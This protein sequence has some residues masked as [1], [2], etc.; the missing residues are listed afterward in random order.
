METAMTSKV[1]S[2]RKVLYMTELALL[3]AIVILMAFTPLGYL[4]TPF[5]EITFIVVPVAIGA[6]LLDWKAGAFLGFV[7]GLTS[8]AQCFG[9]SPFGTMIFNLYPAR[10]AFCCIAP[11]IMVGIVPALA[12]K[13]L[14]SVRSLKALSI[15][16]ACV[17]APLTNT[18]LYL[19][20]MCFI[21][22]GPFTE[23]YGYTGKGGIYFLFWVLAMVMVNALMEAASCLVIASAITKALMH[24]VNRNS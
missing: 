17:L 12:Y 5:A 20:C 4:K 6:V 22:Q 23:A 3:T 24:T 10:T 18:L 7:F 8:L 19:A 14:R 2:G 16:V 11:R 15:P 13:G 1:T 21:M 9:M